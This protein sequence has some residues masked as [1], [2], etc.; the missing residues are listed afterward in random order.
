L[1]TLAACGLVPPAAKQMYTGPAQS[2]NSLAAISEGA[3][4]WLHVVQVDGQYVVNPVVGGAPFTSGLLVLP[5]PHKVRVKYANVD[6][7]SSGYD[8]KV[9]TAHSETELPLETVAGHSY[10]LQGRRTA[11]NY[12][13]WFVDKGLG[14]PQKCLG[15]SEYSAKFLRGETVPGC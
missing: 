8:G 7:F 6:S 2:A 1:L 11:G 10:V 13:F 14:Y 5:G 4:G 3:R 15:P 12:Q 9:V